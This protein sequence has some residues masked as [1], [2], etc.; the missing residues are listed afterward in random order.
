MQFSPHWHIGG[1]FIIGI[2][3]ALVGV[4]LMLVCSAV[5][6]PFFRGEVMSPAPELAPLLVDS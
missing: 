1:V 5:F 6:R 3:S 2:A 4:I